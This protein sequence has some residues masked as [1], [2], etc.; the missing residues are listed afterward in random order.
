VG[1]SDRG[2]D[3]KGAGYGRFND[4]LCIWFFPA[5]VDLKSVPLDRAAPFAVAVLLAAFVEV[6]P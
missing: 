1:K 5:A 3:V 2:S 6:H 4:T